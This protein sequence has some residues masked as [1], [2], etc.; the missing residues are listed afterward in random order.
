[1]EQPMPPQEAYERLL[2][3]LCARLGAQ[4]SVLLLHAPGDQTPGAVVR[5][6][7]ASNP[8]P[9]ATWLEIPIYQGASVAGAL[10][11]AFGPN[12]PLPELVDHS[13]AHPL[14]E[15]AALLAQ[16]GQTLTWVP[17]HTA[18]Q[19]ML[20]VSEE[21][22]QRIILDIHDGPVQKLFAVSS[23]LALLQARLADHPPE[24]CAELAPPLSRIEGLVQSALQEIK[25]SI[26]IFRPAEFQ[27][28]PLPSVI[29]GLAMQH[30]ALT[31][32]Q[33]DLTI[34]GPIP[35]VSLPVKIA[36][37]R[38]LQEALSNAHRHA[39]V[40]RHTVRLSR[41]GAW[42]ELEV[43]DEG[44]GF[45]PPPLEGPGATEREEHIGLRGM[46]ERMH[47]VGGQFRVIS[48]PGGGTR[49]IV[50]VACHE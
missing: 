48:Q 13:N 5:A 4:E 39:G 41:Q 32:N 45:T 10:R 31:G 29:Q 7:Q 37:Y 28:R 15:L 1:M 25:S 18:G 47:L 17:T 38:V 20:A 22:L 11:M 46:R 19:R 8:A 36:L 16:R 24:L 2:G 6:V 3:E 50:R 9:A 42:V 23:H 33:V 21:E 49:V 44:R 34:E 40:D 30:E 12:T 43:T 35:P 26:S 27:R 14:V